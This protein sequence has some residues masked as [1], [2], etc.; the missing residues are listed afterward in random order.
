[1]SAAASTRT[2]RARTPRARGAAGHPL[3]IGVFIGLLLGLCLALAVACPA[4]MSG[5]DLGA[6]LA[7]IRAVGPEGQGNAAAAPAWRKLAA[8]DRASLPTLLSGMS[9]ANEF[10]AN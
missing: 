5:D 3:L 4:E 9:G 7:A 10:A 1:M 2:N 6:A 8:L